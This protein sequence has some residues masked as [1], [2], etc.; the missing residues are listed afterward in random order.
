MDGQTHTDRQIVSDI[1]ATYLS[2][3]QTQWHTKKLQKTNQRARASAFPRT[4]KKVSKHSAEH[5]K[6]FFFCEKKP[7]S[8][9]MKNRLMMMININFFGL[10]NEPDGSVCPEHVRYIKAA[11]ISAQNH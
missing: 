3:F 4:N 9:L 10:T 7:L 11:V 6:K 2:N 5:S 8:S 1:D